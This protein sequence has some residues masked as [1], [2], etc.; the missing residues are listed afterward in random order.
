MWCVYRDKEDMF[1]LPRIVLFILVTSVHHEV[2]FDPLHS[3]LSS[4][5]GCIQTESASWIIKKALR[6]G[7]DALW[8][9]A[10]V[11]FCSSSRFLWGRPPSPCSG[12]PESLFSRVRSQSERR[13]AQQPPCHTGLSTQ[14]GV[15][16]VIWHH[17]A[18][19]K[20]S[21]HWRDCKSLSFRHFYVYSRSI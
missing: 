7:L 2:I 12:L 19:Q 11:L 9:K 21:T 1:D 3:C 14:G 13:E 15:L 20:C 8:D 18:A 10:E 6:R 16:A 17:S 5:H 4:S